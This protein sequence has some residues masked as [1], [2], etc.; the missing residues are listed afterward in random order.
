[1]IIQLNI[2]LKLKLLLYLISATNSQIIIFAVMTF[3]FLKFRLKYSLA[4]YRAAQTGKPDFSETPVGQPL[5][6][7]D[8]TPV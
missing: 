6:L 3:R 8:Q 4:A 7:A 5:R 1:M 2:Q